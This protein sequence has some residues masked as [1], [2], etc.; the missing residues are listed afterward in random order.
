MVPPK[1]PHAQ[2]VQGLE[3]QYDIV[4]CRGGWDQN[5]PTMQLKPGILRD[6]LN[7]EV[8]NTGGYSRVGGY[9]RTDGRSAPSSATYVIVQVV[10]F[11]NTPSI[12]QPLDGVSGGAHSGTIAYVGANYMVV[13]ALTGTAT[14]VD[15]E[16]VTTTGPVTVGVV[17]ALT[18][19]ITHKLAA[20]FMNYAADVY[21]ALI[22][23]VPGDATTETVLGVVV[24]NDVKYAFKKKAGAALVEMYKST[25][26]GWTLV[27]FLYEVSF[28]NANSFVSEGDTLTNNGQTATI[29]RVVVQSGTLASGIN[30]GRLIVQSPTGAFSGT[31]ASSAV[32]IGVASPAV[33]TWV[34]HGRATDSIVTF[35]TTGTL[36]APLVAGTPYYVTSTGADT[37][38]LSLTIGGAAINTTVLGSGTHTAT[39]SNATATGSGSGVLTL[40]GNYSAITLATGS[41]QK[42]EFDIERFSGQGQSGSKRLYGCDGVNRAFEFDGDYFVPITSALTTDAPNHIKAHK[43][44]LFI[45]YGTSILSSGIGAPYNWTVTA[46]ASEINIGDTVTGFSSLPGSDLTAALLIGGK[47]KMTILY[48]TSA[49]LSGNT[50]RPE[51]YANGVGSIPYSIQN[52]SQTYFMGAHGVTSLQASQIFGNFEDATLTN[53]I[54]KF[55]KEKVPYVSCS[56]VSKERSQYRIFF[57]DGYALY[58]TIING[59][60]VGAAQ[61]KFP[62]VPYCASS[63]T[64]STGEEVLLI[65]ATDGYV[66][67][68]DKG[69]SFDGADIDWHA[70]FAWNFAGS[71]RVLKRWRRCSIEMQGEH[72]AELNF[73]YSLA[74]GGTDEMQPSSANYIANMAYALWDVGPYWDS[75]LP[76]WDAQSNVPVEVEMEGTSVNH[77]VTVSG[78]GDYIMP[79]TLNSFIY[80]Y[81][82]RRGIRG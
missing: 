34:A 78:T 17:T 12:G 20:Q 82:P 75:G 57:S 42:F 67:Q 71:P 68:L 53:N 7:A 25:T 26:S 56:G 3:V 15:G 5:T 61:I 62:F 2:N 64:L 49:D 8:S 39:A 1:R 58:V 37:F 80:H 43:N 31:V 77:Q 63:S 66:Y 60:F 54:K 24:Y 44:H 59:K 51:S 22:G 27:D 23:K 35:S 46:G 32:T 16:T 4:E 28:T 79:F 38:T 69:S 74:W 47:S 65:G 19:S 18:I 10:S 45:S 48:G 41:N 13:T 21:R 30:S 29:R 55:I 72:Y 81:T 9:E 14:Y 70:T 50:W 76:F 11:T 40:T 52:M 73:G 33:V 6:V 36:D